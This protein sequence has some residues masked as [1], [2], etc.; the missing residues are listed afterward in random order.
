MELIK[1]IAFKIIDIDMPITVAALGTGVFLATKFD[2]I[3]EQILLKH[4]V[5]AAENLKQGRWWTLL[6]STFTYTDIGNL[7]KLYLK[8]ALLRRALKSRE[9][10][11]FKNR[12][13]WG[14][15][16][17]GQYLA[18]LAA[19]KIPIDNVYPI[20]KGASGGFYATFAML[21]TYGLQLKEIHPWDH[22]GHLYLFFAFDLLMGDFS[23]AK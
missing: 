16:L 17:V 10:E 11:G 6:T 13:M 4:F 9:R 20:V 21:C 23:L 19:Y 8:M 14:T 12:H 2:I 18:N 7:F 1:E 3:P 15:F 5:L 22:L